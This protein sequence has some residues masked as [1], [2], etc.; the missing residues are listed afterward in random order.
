M[1]QSLVVFSHGKESEPWGS[2][3]QALAAIAQR[4]GSQVISVDYR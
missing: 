1:I 4:H 3:F 2:K